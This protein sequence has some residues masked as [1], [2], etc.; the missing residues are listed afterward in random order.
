[1]YAF[2]LFFHMNCN[3]TSCNTE[4]N[5]QTQIHATCISKNSVCYLGHDRVCIHVYYIIHYE[6]NVSMRCFPLLHLLLFFR[7]FYFACL[8]VL[9]VQMFKETTNRKL[10]LLHF[11]VIDWNH[12]RGQ[13]REQ[14]A[15]YNRINVIFNGMYKFHRIFFRLSLW[16]V[17][18]TQTVLRR[19]RRIC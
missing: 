1:M 13:W 5:L 16:N 19:W 4:A 6:Q 12:F 3:I 11:L 9:F 7:F 17:I 10:H 8:F 14:N 2:V 18:D 15:S